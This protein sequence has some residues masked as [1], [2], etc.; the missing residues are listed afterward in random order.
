MDRGA[1]C[2]VVC[3]RSGKGSTGDLVMNCGDLRLSANFLLAAL[4]IDENNPSFSAC[5][6]SG[7][8][9]GSGNFIGHSF[10]GDTLP[11]SG[12]DESGVLSI[13][14]VV[15]ECGLSD[16]EADLGDV[17]SLSDPLLDLSDGLGVARLR[18][19]VLVI[20]A[21]GDADLSFSDPR[22]DLSVGLGVFFP[23]LSALERRRADSLGDDR[24]PS[25]SLLERSLSELLLDLSESDLG[26]AESARVRQ[27]SGRVG[28]GGRVLWEGRGVLPA[29]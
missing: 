13:V 26:R 28:R 22:R 2:S 19:S 17:F 11:L 3:F 10:F 16:R 6:L 27:M 25:D 8:F 15:G 4:F 20:G 1:S 12:F 23:R 5:G 21:L 9:S 24:S 29:G 18:S 14:D 7:A